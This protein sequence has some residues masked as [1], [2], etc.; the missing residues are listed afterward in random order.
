MRGTIT[1]ESIDKHVSKSVK[2]LNIA[3]RT[4]FVMLPAMVNTTDH[5]I[6]ASLQAEVLFCYSNMLNVKIF[7]T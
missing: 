2:Q 5:Y 7:V 6:V 4:R 1:A 3:R